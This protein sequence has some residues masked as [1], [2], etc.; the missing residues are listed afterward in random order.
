MKKILV[1]LGVLIASGASLHASAPLWM[2][3]V[4]ISPDGSRIA[5]TY[6]G[7]IYTVP[8]AGGTATRLT[9]NPAYDTY[10]VWSP[11]GSRIAFASDREGGFDVYVMP[12]TGGE[13][14]RLT[15]HST[16]ES[17]MAFTPDGKSVVYS[18]AIQL[19]ASSIL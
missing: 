19:P 17:P 4:N 3:N 1:G 11:D 9:T 15:F 7:D 14:K 5:F 18:A 8:A 16:S 13:A 2:R 12:S 10:P 6:K